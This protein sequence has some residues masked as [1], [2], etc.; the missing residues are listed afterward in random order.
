[1]RSNRLIDLEKIF[2]LARQS[3]KLSQKTNL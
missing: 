1:M 3:E 2:S